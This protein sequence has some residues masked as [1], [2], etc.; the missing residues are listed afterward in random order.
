MVLPL[1]ES[2]Y[3]MTSLQFMRQGLSSRE[4]SAMVLIEPNPRVPYMSS[5]PSTPSA[6][7]KPPPCASPA[8]RLAHSGKGTSIVSPVWGS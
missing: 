7:T 2:V 8:P 1:P 6:P 5:K 3:S 4:D